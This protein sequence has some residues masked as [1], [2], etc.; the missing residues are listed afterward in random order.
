MIVNQISTLADN[1]TPSNFFFFFFFERQSNFVWEVLFTMAIIGVG[2]L[3]F[4]LLIG[5]IQNFLQGLGRRWLETSLRRR[6][7][8]QWMSHRH[9]PDELRK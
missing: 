6:D 2:L 4:A 3:L 8:E 9:L 5:N 1:Q 7:V